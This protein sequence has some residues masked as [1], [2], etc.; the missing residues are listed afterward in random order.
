M[1]QK[2]TWRQILFIARKQQVLGQINPSSSLKDSLHYTLLSNQTR[3]KKETE[4]KN[5]F[6]FCIKRRE[7]TNLKEQRDLSGTKVHMLVKSYKMWKEN[8]LAIS[9][10]ARMN[11]KILSVNPRRYLSNI[12]TIA[13]SS[14]TKQESMTSSRM[15]APSRSINK[16]WAIWTSW[17]RIAKLPSPREWAALTEWA[18]QREAVMPIMH[19]MW[20]HNPKN[21]RKQWFLNMW[22]PRL[23]TSLLSKSDWCQLLARNKEWQPIRTLHS[24]I[25]IKHSWK[26]LAVSILKGL[27]KSRINL[28]SRESFL[29]TNWWITKRWRRN[30]SRRRRPTRL[31][32]TLDRQC[33]MV[34]SQLPTQSWEWAIKTR[35]QDHRVHMSS[36]MALHQGKCK[37]S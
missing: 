6:P 5:C 36:T 7:I 3:T 24:L 21:R 28:L 18:Q 35:T 31:R 30:Y 8:S 32:E 12:K 26:M 10:T 34:E 29:T 4:K 22:D 27:V 2:R 14:R 33:L 23:Q 1:Q 13:Q 15:K 16:M 9:P 19:T 11:L 37:T 25:I 17:K 20:L